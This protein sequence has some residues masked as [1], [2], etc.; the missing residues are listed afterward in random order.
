[1]SE[2]WCSYGTLKTLKRTVYVT[3]HRTNI[4]SF[5]GHEETDAEVGLVVVAELALCGAAVSLME[6]RKSTGNL[7]K[8]TSNPSKATRNTSYVHEVLGHRIEFS[9]SKSKCVERA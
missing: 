6:A 5:L 1:M 2:L 9:S 4:Q 7:R 3:L 8:T